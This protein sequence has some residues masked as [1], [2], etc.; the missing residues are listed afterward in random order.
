MLIAVYPSGL[1]LVS[2]GDHRDCTENG[3]TST[4][5]KIIQ[6]WLSGRRFHEW[7]RTSKPDPEMLDHYRS[8]V[9]LLLDTLESS[10]LQKPMF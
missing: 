8:D 1:K 4:C 10:P 6:F 5:S 9:T 2:V 7:V 3:W